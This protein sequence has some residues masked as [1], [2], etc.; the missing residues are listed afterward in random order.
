MV[1]D[2]YCYGGIDIYRDVFNAIAMLNGDHRFMHSLMTIGVIV[3]AFWSLVIMVGGD[4]VRPFLSWMIPMTVI[5][6]VFLTPTKTVHLID[7]VQAGRH[8]TVDNVPYGLALMA[9]TLSRLS[10]KI[11]EKTETFFTIPNDL[12]YST[13]GGIFAAN[14]LANQK[15]MTIQDEDFSENMRRFIS[16][17]VLYDVALGRKY[18]LKDL[19]NTHNI[20]GLIATHASPARSFLWKENRNRGDIITCQEGVTRFN[21]VWRTVLNQTA[22]AVGAY[23]YPNHDRVT[24]ALPNGSGV[25][26]GSTAAPSCRSPL[27]KRE[28]LKFLPLHFGTLAAMSGAA[29]DMLRQQMMIS[30][31][32]DAQDQAS[33]LAGNASNFAARKAYLQQRSTYETIGKLAS[34]TLPIMRA[35]LELICY[36]LF[37]FIMPLLVLPQGY[38]VLVSWA[39]TILWLTMWPPMYAILHLIMVSAISMKTK[40]FMGISNP[41]GITLA[42][43]LGVQNI[44]ADMA[45]MAGY[46]SMSIPFI[47]IAIVKGI[48]SFVHMSSSLGAVSQGVATSASVEGLT[49]NYQ[50][51]NTSMDN[52]SVGNVIMLSENYSGNLSSGNMRLQEGHVSITSSAD[53]GAIASIEQSNLP[54]SV[55]MA[56]SIA[57]NQRLAASHEMS[58][59][60]AQQHSAERSLGSSIEQLGSLGETLTQSTHRQ[61][62]W[63]EQQQ[64]DSGHAMQMVHQATERL[65]QDAHM[66]KGQAASVLASI[67][68]PGLAQMVTGLSGA[69]N[70]ESNSMNQ[71]TLIKAKDI[72]Q[73]FQFDEQARIAMQATEH[74]SKTSQDEHVKS[75]ARH[76]QAS[77]SETAQSHQSAQK[78]KEN[79][80]RLT[81]EA[82]FTESNSV[83]INRNY[84]EKLIDYIASHDAPNVGGALGKR[85]ATSIIARNDEVTQTYLDHFMRDHAPK[86]AQTVTQEGLNADYTAASVGLVVDKGVVD[87]FDQ[88]A[89]AEMSDTL[90]RGTHGIETRVRHKR[91]GTEG[92]IKEA[93]ADVVDSS[94]TALQKAYERHSTDVGIATALKGGL[95]AL[96]NTIQS[97]SRFVDETVDD[98]K[99]LYK[100]LTEGEQPSRTNHDVMERVA[101]SIE[102]TKGSIVME[103]SFDSM[104]LA[105]FSFL[106]ADVNAVS[107]ISAEKPLRAS[108][109]TRGLQEQSSIKYISEHGSNTNQLDQMGMA[110]DVSSL[111]DEGM[112]KSRNEDEHER[113]RES[114]GFELAQSM[115]GDEGGARFGQSQVRG[116]SAELRGQGYNDQGMDVARAHGVRSTVHEGISHERRS[117]PDDD[118]KEIGISEPV[119]QNMGK[120][121]HASVSRQAAAHH[122]HAWE[123]RGM[124]GIDGIEDSQARQDV[125]HIYASQEVYTHTDD[126]GG[127]AEHSPKKDDL[128][129]EQRD[130]SIIHSDQ[131]ADSDLLL[132]TA[133][134]ESLD[135][136]HDGRMESLFKKEEIVQD[137]QQDVKRVKV[138]K[139]KEVPV[140][141]A[142]LIMDQ[143]VRSAQDLLTKG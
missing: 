47:C 103:R 96:G 32:V 88:H 17:C 8:E 73:Q 26:A 60:I 124:R 83:S 55:N 89:K 111:P 52:H 91:E 123:E 66:S 58:M 11:T 110:S 115:R 71:E 120:R 14:L 38:K 140:Q 142:S 102:R 48:S 82:D 135:I 86:H 98:V 3:G 118:S 128:I 114:Q 21:G 59:G 93:K 109:E 65:A 27:A 127:L 99:G 78:H 50:L 95:A 2:I 126:V 46:L 113:V 56:Q 141:D 94:Y 45:S 22:C 92:A 116:A 137:V 112:A 1:S 10:H 68:A 64:Y 134:L 6:T 31:L 69:A 79:A 13:T 54:V 23:L 90:T 39:Q 100:T 63:T 44:S 29:G 33:V 84:N 4:M 131:R 62:G 36:S 122:D 105:S 5:Q 72:S 12:K 77:L 125:P 136:Q 132:G 129:G 61:E 130:M 97:P 75:M 53:G 108:E 74:L 117:Y 40:A 104:S 101:D 133:S 80:K 42:S 57:N 43:A 138:I 15:I 87:Q 106:Q 7:V 49:G 20:W 34:D 107:S 67:G 28:F 35:V 70:L 30:A 24:A 41:Q 139:I 121:G 18:T 143:S 25:S 76:Q 119:G 51:A 81:K 37:I 19:R 16:Q 85:E 9:G